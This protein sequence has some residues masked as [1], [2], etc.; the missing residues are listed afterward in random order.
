MPTRNEWEDIV[1]GVNIAVDTI[2][3]VLVLVGAIHKVIKA[4]EES[5]AMQLDALQDAAEAIKARM[6]ELKFPLE[7]ERA[8]LGI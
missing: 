3:T 7:T 4:Q 8:K 2:P 6:D 1:K 5:P